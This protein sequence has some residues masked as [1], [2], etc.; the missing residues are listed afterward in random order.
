[1]LPKQPCVICGELFTPKRSD[2]IYC[3]A[4]LQAAWLSPQA[5]AARG[6]ATQDRADGNGLEYD[7]CSAPSRID[8]PAWLKAWSLSKRLSPVGDSLSSRCSIPED[9]GTGGY[10]VAGQ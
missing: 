8:F 7:D 3:S 4:A 6:R 5:N 1:M 10:A 2:A 9:Y